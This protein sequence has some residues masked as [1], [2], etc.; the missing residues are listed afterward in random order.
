M[1]QEN[2]YPKPYFDKIFERFLTE[3]DA[4]EKT[5]PDTSEKEN[6]YI[7][8]PYL[9]SESRCFINNFAKIIKNKINVNI[10]PVYKSFKI[11][12]YFQLKSNTPLA[13]CSNI[14]YKFTCSCDMNL[15]Y[16]GMSTLHLITKVRKH[17]DFNSIQ[18]SATKD[19]IFSC[20]ICSDVQY[21]LK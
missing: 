15:T 6:Y 4:K 17:L 9:E 8:I 16:Y 12:R 5:I 11:G 13:L 18:R 21:G 2:G 19:Y 1:F 3:Q 7:T 14:V 20:D 10:A